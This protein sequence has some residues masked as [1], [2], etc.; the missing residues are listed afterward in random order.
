MDLDPVLNNLLNIFF[1]KLLSLYLSVF[2]N[3]FL[4]GRFIILDWPGRLPVL[5][6]TQLY[7]EIELRTEVPN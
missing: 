6:F 1:L 2:F 3:P 4:E 7:Q 5:P